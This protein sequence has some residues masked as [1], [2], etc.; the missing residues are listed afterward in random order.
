ME[1]ITHFYGYV[2]KGNIDSSSTNKIYIT[3]IFRDYLGS[4]KSRQPRAERKNN[5]NGTSKKKLGF[6]HNHFSSINPLV[7]GLGFFYKKRKAFKKTREKVVK[8]TC[9][10]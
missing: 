7:S 8:Q 3:S 5:N 9:S 2:V 6:H 10:S 4:P 1:S